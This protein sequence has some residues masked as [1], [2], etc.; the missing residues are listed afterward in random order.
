MGLLPH[1]KL[2]NNYFT[3]LENR[4]VAMSYEQ[5]IAALIVMI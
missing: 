5:S 3:L 1:R 4:F 2:V